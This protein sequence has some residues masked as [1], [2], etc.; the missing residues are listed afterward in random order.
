MEG[1][2]CGN[3]CPF[4]IQGFCK[5]DRECPHYVESVWVEGSTQETK[6][7]RDCSP[8]RILIQNQRLECRL[9]EVQKKLEVSIVEYQRLS[10][11]L[12]ELIKASKRVILENEK[13]EVQYENIPVKLLPVN[14][15][16]LLDNDGSHRGEC[17]GCGG[18]QSKS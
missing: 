5:S 18:Q 9:E 12:E 10:G 8:K 2:A 14:E 16:H 17:D 6:I 3:K 11:Y 13:K 1:T 4:V 7:I 15:L